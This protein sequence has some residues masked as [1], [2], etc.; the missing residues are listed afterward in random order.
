MVIIHGLVPKIA[1]ALG[2]LE[3]ATRKFELVYYR[4]DSLIVNQLIWHVF[5]G[6]V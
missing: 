3:M 5:K 2:E 4:L 6:P 1:L